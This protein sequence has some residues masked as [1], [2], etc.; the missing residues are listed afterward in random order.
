M[1]IGSEVLANDYVRA[2]EGTVDITDVKIVVREDVVSPVFMDQ[3]LLVNES[4]FGIHHGL[5]GVVVNRNKFR[6]VFRGVAT[7]GH[8]DRNQITDM[9]HFVGG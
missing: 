6:C 7:F 4:A 2:G 8:H 9:A 3:I 1:P 5:Q